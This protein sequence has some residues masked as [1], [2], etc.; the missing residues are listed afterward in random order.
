M[1]NKILKGFSVE[2]EGGSREYRGEY[3]GL[4]LYELIGGRITAIAIVDEP[5]IGINCVVN[6][7]EQIIAGPVMIPDI[8]IYRRNETEEYYVYFSTE[9]ISN[10]KNTYTGKIKLGH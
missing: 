5:A 9:T 4:P 2:W 7:K 3:N 8:K 1:Y 6:D 10:L